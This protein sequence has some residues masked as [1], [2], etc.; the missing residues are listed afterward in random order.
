MQGKGHGYIRYKTVEKIL[1]RYGGKRLDINFLL[2]SVC[3][4]L[5]NSLSGQKLQ[6]FEN[7]REHEKHYMYFQDCINRYSTSAAAVIQGVKNNED[8]GMTTM[9][10]IIG[11]PLTSVAIPVWLSTSGELPSIITGNGEKKS[12]LCNFSLQLKKTLIAAT[13]GDMRY[14]INTT[15]LK[16]IEGTGILQRID[17]VRKEVFQR[18]IGLKEKLKNEK[19]RDGKIKMYYE[20]LDSY[21][22]RELQGIKELYVR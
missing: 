10:T 3:F 9:W 16:N 12:M 13:Y 17:P 18:G 15:G 11:F 22:K 2:N 5:E 4:S 1:E 19:G 20:W 21:L 7:A 6:D 8:S 14:Y